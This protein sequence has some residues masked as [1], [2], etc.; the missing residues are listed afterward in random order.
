M[1]KKAPASTEQIAAYDAATIMDFIYAGRRIT[2]NG[3]LGV[4]V[5]PVN[6][7][8][9]EA[10]RVFALTDSKR[11]VIG[12]CYR[13]ARFNATTSWGVLT[14]SYVFGAILPPVPKDDLA[15]WEAC[16]YTA[17]CEVKSRRMED[18][19][20]KRGYIDTQLA[21]LR[22]MYDKF[23]Q[24]GRFEDAAVLEAAV[25]RSLRRKP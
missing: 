23:R 10:P 24:S 20:K 15:L 4:C 13:G 17:E 6:G 12:G 18:D 11:R 8:T 1:S 3:K 14:A 9:L 25:L 16:D 7:S 22:E 21:E 19:A 5:I 2:S